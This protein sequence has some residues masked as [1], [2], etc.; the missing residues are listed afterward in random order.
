MAYLSF[1]LH[2]RCLLRRL[3]P[4]IPPPVST[5]CPP[6]LAKRND[7]TFKWDMHPFIDRD[8]LR[9]RSSDD[10]PRTG[11]RASDAQVRVLLPGLGLPSLANTRSR[12]IV[13]VQTYRVCRYD[14]G[15]VCKC[16]Q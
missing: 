4:P 5:L 2:R 16:K 10:A 3:Y 12:G 11:G 13:R 1:L 6:P 14:H 15:R 8:L 9:R 7:Y